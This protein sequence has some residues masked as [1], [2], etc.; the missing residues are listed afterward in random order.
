[1]FYQN[2]EAPPYRTRKKEQFLRN[3]HRGK[4][5][6]HH[7]PVNLPPRDPDITPM[8]SWEYTI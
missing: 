6:A 7:R 5:I 4:I 3:R 1:M 8:D 2:D